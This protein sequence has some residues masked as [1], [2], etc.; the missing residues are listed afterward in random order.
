[1]LASHLPDAV[2]SGRPPGAA[3]PTPLTPAD[4]ALRDSLC[5]AMR[6]HRGNISAVARALNKD[7]KQIQRW[8]K[9]FAVDPEKFK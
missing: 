1:V 9:R 7:R 8:V 5:A 4:E 2:R 3:G 6:D